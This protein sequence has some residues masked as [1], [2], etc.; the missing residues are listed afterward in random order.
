MIGLLD[1]GDSIVNQLKKISPLKGYCWREVQEKCI[2]FASLG[3][4]FYQQA[5]TTQSGFGM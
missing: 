3:Q 4:A 5:Q 2:V 1:Y